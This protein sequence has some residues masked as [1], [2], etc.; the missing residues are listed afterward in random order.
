MESP[1]YWGAILAAA[2]GGVRV[3]PVPSGPDGPDPAEL[4]RAFDESGARLFYAQPNYSNPTGAQWSAQRRE[5]V[6]EVVRAKGAFLVEDDWAHDFGIT[7]DPVPVASRDDSGH[8]VYLRSLTKSPSA[9]PRS[10]P[11]ARRGSA[12]WRTGQPNRCT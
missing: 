5:Q 8:V 1:S 4:A 2:Q 12:S 3:V 6:L 7:S 9:S 10:S 11:A